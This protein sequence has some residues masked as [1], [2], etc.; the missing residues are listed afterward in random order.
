M[1]GDERHKEALTLAI[2]TIAG[3]MMF[4]EI[5]QNGSEGLDAHGWHQIHWE[6]M[7][8]LVGGMLGS[9]SAILAFIWLV[10]MAERRAPDPDVVAPLTEEEKAVVDAVLRLNLELEGSEND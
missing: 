4:I 5:M 2:L 9:I 1:M 3:G 10:Y 6:Q 8:F 7:M